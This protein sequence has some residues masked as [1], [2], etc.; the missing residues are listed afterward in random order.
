LKLI[1]VSEGGGN[2]HV[3]NVCHFQQGELLYAISTQHTQ[4]FLKSN[5]YIYYSNIN[6]LVSKPWFHRQEVSI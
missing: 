5:M 2:M 6:L 4:L 1:V 3:W